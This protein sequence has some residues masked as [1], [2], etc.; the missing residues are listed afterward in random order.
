MHSM[1][2]KGYYD[3]GTLLKK[4]QFQTVLLEVNKTKGKA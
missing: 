4:P 3:V 2:K 1:N